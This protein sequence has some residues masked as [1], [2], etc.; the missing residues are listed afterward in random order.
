MVALTPRQY[1]RK[2]IEA[3]SIPPASIPARAMTTQITGAGA[4]WAQQ[5]GGGRRQAAQHQRP[6][7]ADVDDAQPGGQ[8]GAEGRQDE[9]RRPVRVS[10]QADCVPKPPRYIQ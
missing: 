1:C 8:G 10:S 4:A 5:P 6:F 7:A 2:P 9:R 3:I